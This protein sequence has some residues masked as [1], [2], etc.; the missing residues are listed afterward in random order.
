MYPV[1][2]CRTFVSTLRKAHLKGVFSLKKGYG[3]ARYKLYNTGKCI[4]QVKMKGVQGIQTFKRGVWRFLTCKKSH[5][6]VNIQLTFSKKINT[7]ETF[8]K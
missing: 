4:N 8:Q 7:E 3:D 6:D 1:K 5:V 2:Q